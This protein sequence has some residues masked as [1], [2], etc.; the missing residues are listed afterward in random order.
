MTSPA[1]APPTS[2]GIE[3]AMCDGAHQ[4]P[5]DTLNR[6]EALRRRMDE[7]DGKIE[8]RWNSKEQPT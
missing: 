6:I 3:L 8:T 2:L 7:C 1:I 5:D 4:P